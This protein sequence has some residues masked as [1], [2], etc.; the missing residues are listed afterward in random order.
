MGVGGSPD[1]GI[2]SMAVTGLAR[3][4]GL[5]AL[6]GC[7]A[8]AAGPAAPQREVEVVSTPVVS[9]DEPAPAPA[10]PERFFC[11]PTARGDTARV[12]F[13]MGSRFGAVD[14]KGVDLPGV[15]QPLRATYTITVLELEGAQPRA[16]RLRLETVDRSEGLLLGTF[17]WGVAVDNGWLTPG[18]AFTMVRDADGW[19]PE[20]AGAAPAPPPSVAVV[21]AAEAPA[22]TREAFFA[23]LGSPIELVALAPELLRELD[24]RRVTDVKALRPPPSVARQLGLSEPTATLPRDS[25]SLPAR[26]A[27]TV[28]TTQTTMRTT[29]GA[30]GQPVP[31]GEQNQYTTV[32]RELTLGEDCRVQRLA[33]A[34]TVWLPLVE[35][36]LPSGARIVQ[37]VSWTIAAAG[38]R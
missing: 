10:E 38:P 2:G 37:E 29:P 31:A 14:A 21:P 17:A 7:A 9:I 11:R 12:T 33:I 23:S 22:L 20:A 18:A 1:M 25:A 8:R 13:E 32:S 34:T 5:V 36:Q 15:S 16:A 24:G 30:D 28:E 4:M 26:F 35:G 19:R 3:L 27:S 6:A